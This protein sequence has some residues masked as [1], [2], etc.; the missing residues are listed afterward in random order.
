M[1]YF[2]T[3][4]PM[5]VGTGSQLCLKSSNLSILSTYDSASLCVQGETTDTRLYY[6]QL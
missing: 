3:L 1:L 4:L 5:L 2:Q 6:L